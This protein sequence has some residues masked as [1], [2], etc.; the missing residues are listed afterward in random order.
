[1]AFGGIDRD[2]R[3]LRDTGVDVGVSAGFVALEHGADRSWRSTAVGVHADGTRERPSRRAAFDRRV[4]LSGMSTDVDSETDAALA[5]VA[6]ALV[7]GNGAMALT[8]AG[9]STASGVPS[10]R[11]DDGIWETEFDP[12][13]FHYSRFLRDPAG[14]WADR[15]RL[16]EVLFPG[17]LEP[18][19]AHHALVALEE[20]GVL[21][22]VATQNTD[23]LHHAA[24][25]PTLAELHGNAARVECQS[26]GAMTDAGPVFDR[27]RD[28][29]NPPRCDCGGLY[30]P[31]VVLFG[32]NLDHETL[33][34]AEDLAMGSE[35]VLA[36]GTSLQVNPAASLAGLGDRLVIVNFDETPYS[37]EA[38][39][40]LRADVTTALPRLVELVDERL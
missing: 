39:V 30:K 35:T 4:P 13:D 7:E 15:L 5:G 36:V 17:E 27:V 28:G 2:D 16:Q 19:A 18:N 10:F 9:V 34:R 6:D 40:D 33:A 38:T 1:M 21:D 12:T 14:F 24:G 20:R 25:Q 8:G 26:C 37:T 22:G 3:R 23:G 31:D 11:G 29:D 32:E